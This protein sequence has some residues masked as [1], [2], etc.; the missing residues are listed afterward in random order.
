[1]VA[2]RGLPQEDGYVQC[3]A[4]SQY[5]LVPLL[6]LSTDICGVLTALASNMSR[7]ALLILLFKLSSILCFLVMMNSVKSN[8]ITI[9]RLGNKGMALGKGPILDS[10]K[11]CVRIKNNTTSFRG[12]IDGP[13]EWPQLQ[14]Q[15]AARVRR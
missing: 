2:E 1:M 7:Y 5:P 3:V 8:A 13:L 15:F 10:K 9:A 4:I 14:L 12:P 11:S 6:L